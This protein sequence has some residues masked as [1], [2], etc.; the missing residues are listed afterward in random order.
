MIKIILVDNDVR[1]YL[2][3]KKIITKLDFLYSK[4]LSISWYERYTPKLKCDIENS[5]IKKI[6]LIN[7]TYKAKNQNLATFIRTRDYHSELILIGY[8]YQK[9]VNNIFDIVPNIYSYSKQ[10][11]LD[12]KNI[13]DNYHIGNMF[14]YQNRNYSLSIYY[15]NILFIYRDT[16]KRKVVIVTDNNL[17]SLCMSL[18]EI[19]NHLDGRFKQVH[20]A[21][22]LNTLR[23]H[24]YNWSKNYFVL[25][26]G[27]KIELL[28]KKY[29]DEI[30]I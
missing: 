5:E 22:L 29:K 7:N 17:Y 19:K 26:N 4:N 15:D 30:K 13:L 1:N 9:W 8:Y 14:R 12:L 16:S 25:D 24:K 18:N 2:T 27:Q 3:L 23:V 21:C 20:R 10:I 6:Y 28:S 11:L